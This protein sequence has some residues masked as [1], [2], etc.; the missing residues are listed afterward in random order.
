MAQSELIKDEGKKMADEAGG[1]HSPVRKAWQRLKKHRLAV[2]SGIVLLIIYFLVIFA[3]FISPYHWRT[4]D[5][6][7]PFHPPAR[8]SIFDD[9]RLTRPFVYGY[10]RERRSYTLDPEQKHTIY[11]FVRGDE[12]HFLNL[13]K[14]DIHLFGVEE[15]ARINLLGTDSM[16]RDIFTRLLYGGRV[17]MF[18]GFLG[19]LISFSIGLVVG[20]IS[21]FYGGWVDNLFMRLT[22][23]FMSIPSIFLLIA[24]TAVIPYDI[25][26]PMRFAM[27]VMILAFVGWAGVARIIRGQVLAIREEEFVLAARA[28]G[29]NDFRTIVRHILPST[30][31][32]T[33]IAATLSIPGYI[34]M[35]SGLSFLGLGIQ[36]PYASWG[37]MLSAARS[38]RSMSQYTWTLVPGLMIFIAIL[39]FNIF[40]DGLR[41]AFDPQS[42]L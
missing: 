14:T 13:F 29:A 36:E 26:G 4:S 16:G 31:T 24:L 30:F 38:I 32:Y 19:I 20:G 18:I 17:S 22:E 41:D 15:P 9:G 23:I 39:A 40:G 5:R 1:I 2:I 33:I 8:V 12:Y 21:G 37:N 7:T 11:F 34:L 27:I 25:S 28:L 42:D 6:R 3:D 35:E 10:E